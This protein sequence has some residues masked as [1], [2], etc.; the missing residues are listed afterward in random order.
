MAKRTLSSD[1]LLRDILDIAQKVKQ[2]LSG[3]DEEKFIEAFEFARK[4]HEGQVRKDGSPYIIHPIATTQILS[5]L[6]VD[7]DTLIAAL[8]HDVP[9]DTPHTVQEIEERFGERIAFLV[10]GITKLSKVHYQNDMESRQVESL[11]KLLIHTAKDPRV[12]LI[13]L[14]DRLH[15][16][17]TLHFIDKP[18]KQRRISRE[19]LEIYVP[20]ASLLGIQGI[21]SELEDLCFRYLYP[22]DFQ[23]YSHVIAES[24]QR[25]KP[26]GDETIHRVVDVLRGHG[27]EAQ[28]FQRKKTLLSIFRKIELEHK[29]LDDLND[30][31]TLRVVV[32]TAEDAYRTLGIIHTMFKPRPGSFKDYIA[33][34][35][36]NGY[37]SLHTTIFGIDGTLT[38]FQIRTLEMDNEAD[39]GITTYYFLGSKRKGGEKN[40]EEWRTKWMTQILELE[41]QELDS[42]NFVEKVKADIF[43]DKI[44]VF[45]PKGDAIHLPKGSTA[46]DFAYAIHSD[47][48]NYA[49]SADVNGFSKPLHTTLKSGDTVNIVMDRS[50]CGPQRDWL[51]FA[52]TSVAKNRIREFLNKETSKTK[53]IIGKQLLQKAFYRAG[54]GLIDNI[55]FKR[56]QTS[57]VKNHYPEYDDLQQ[58]LIA[59]GDGSLDAINVIQSLYPD[60][61]LSNISRDHNR[62]GRLL[63]R[64]SEPNECEHISLRIKVF[65]RT[66]MV[67]DIVTV[68]SKLSV[69]LI[70]LSGTSK[71]WFSNE[72]T[73][74]ITFA[75]ERYD[76]L[77]SI[78]SDLEKIDGVISVVRVFRMKEIFFTLFLCFT[79]TFWIAHPFIIEHFIRVSNVSV[80][81]GFLLLLIMGFLLSKFTPRF[82]SRLQEGRSMILATGSITIFALVTLVWEI[83]HYGIILNF[84]T[85][86]MVI[87]VTFYLAYQFWDYKNKKLY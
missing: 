49:M 58:V 83:E 65:D 53:I 67:A 35:K 63:D 60:Q 33:V 74:H 46:I 7:E 68:L 21:K 86:G 80:Y 50:S 78:F 2:Q 1:P 59:I 82:V 18:E 81:T 85:I 55:P 61:K 24:E 47:V 22:E 66:G 84:A 28:V 26:K 16:M 32:P 44:F 70:D 27:I 57:L 17:R 52:K 20:M 30:L 76:T 39:Y 62:F 29:N 87:A 10:E 19:T 51:N 79:I 41:Q 72:A 13:K 6:R 64:V 15:N 23:R 42:R 54:V 43:E 45:T 77:Q 12:I 40:N 11:K 34:P 36:I 8:M 5:Q 25:M 38:E 71:G 48:G 73:V 75:I 37:R 9:E 4:A 3:F 31:V 14:A 69:S 56:I